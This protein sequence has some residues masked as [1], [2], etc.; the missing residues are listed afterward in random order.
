MKFSQLTCEKLGYYVY[1]LIDPFSDKVFYIGKG[2]GNRVYAHENDALEYIM[3]QKEL[4]D[5]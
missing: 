3:Q 2:T 4:S 5:V 1:S